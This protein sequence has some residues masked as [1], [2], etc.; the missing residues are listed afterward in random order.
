MTLQAH[1]S[2]IQTGD[3]VAYE[4]D[5]EIKRIAARKVLRDCGCIHVWDVARVVTFPSGYH[6][7]IAR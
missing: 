2:E 7:E 6:V 5:G 1:A 4:A 3:S